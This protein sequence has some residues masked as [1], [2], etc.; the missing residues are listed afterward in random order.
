MRKTLRS[1]QYLPGAE[2]FHLAHI[3]TQ[4]VLGLVTGCNKQSVHNHHKAWSQHVLRAKDGSG[5][6]TIITTFV[7]IEF[8]DGKRKRG[9]PNA[10][11][12]YHGSGRPHLHCLIWLENI[13]A[14]DLPSVVSATLPDDNEPLRDIIL[15]SQQSYTGSHDRL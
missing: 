11:H 6:N 8:Q 14:I 13:E 2:T 4:S 12:D 7:R 1:K 3:L 10:R 5:K 9:Q 15:G